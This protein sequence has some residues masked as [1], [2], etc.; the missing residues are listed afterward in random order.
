MK[1][2][3]H[4]MQIPQ[5][6]FLF[7]CHSHINLDLDSAAQPNNMPFDLMCNN[8]SLEADHCVVGSPFFDLHR[9]ALPMGYPFEPRRPAQVN[10]IPLD[11]TARNELP[12][13]E[14]NSRSKNK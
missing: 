10:D 11:L 13:S 12:F 3:P 14:P 5:R 7:F 9:Q 1:K 2:K 8:S 6:V 4:K